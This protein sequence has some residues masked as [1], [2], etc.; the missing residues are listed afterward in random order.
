MK[1][2]L[3][4]VRLRKVATLYVGERK[5]WQADGNGGGGCAGFYVSEMPFETVQA[6]AYHPDYKTALADAKRRLLAAEAAMRLGAD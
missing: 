6:T 4:R 5:W 1:R 3:C 2:W